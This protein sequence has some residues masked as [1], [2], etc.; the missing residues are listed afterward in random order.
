MK[1]RET[2]A[3]GSFP[4]TSLSPQSHQP[5]PTQGA[6]EGDLL[7]FLFKLLC[8]LKPFPQFQMESQ[9]LEISEGSIHELLR[10]DT[11]VDKRIGGEVCTE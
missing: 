8:K 9:K 11:G 10:G 7:W 1:E 3:T 4:S 2:E 6:G 5:I